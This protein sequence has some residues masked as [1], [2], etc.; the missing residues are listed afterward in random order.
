[1]SHVSE[2][3]ELPKTVAELTKFLSARGIV[4]TKKK[5]DELEKLAALAVE[6]DVEVDPEGLTEDREETIRKKLNLLDGE[7]ILPL[8]ESLT[9]TSDLTAAPRITLRDILNYQLEAKSV[10][11]DGELKHPYKSEAWQMTRDKFVLEMS[12]AE[13]TDTKF[14]AIQSKVKPRTNQCDPVTK[15]P[16][17]SVWIIISNEDLG[18][19]I[20]SAFCACKAGID[21]HCRHVS[22]TLYKLSEYN[23]RD[24]E[25]T[26]VTSLPC[27]WNKPSL[28]KSV[29]PATL[30][31]LQ[32]EVVPWHAKGVTLQEI[33]QY[34]P[35]P[36]ATAL[37]RVEDFLSMTKEF[38]PQAA[39]LDVFFKRP[40]KEPKDAM[41]NLTVITPHDKIKAHFEMHALMH[42]ECAPVCTEELLD[43][44]KYTKE[45]ALTIDHATRG[46]CDNDN[47]LMMRQGLLTSS[48][49]HNILHSTNDSQ[50]ANQL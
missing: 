22:A 42:D 11:S 6:M 15:L 40:Q 20:R 39:L 33:Q 5:K 43:K 50:K 19:E 23:Q 27:Q 14:V 35:L 46:Q 48:E 16:Y 13:Y 49:F 7:Q 26:S 24:G 18:P 30:Q 38:C 3:P 29:R 44:L 45:E 21:G 2:T 10:Y 28:S 31:E 1:M 17:Y 4:C 34:N 25:K 12:Y 36:A 32:V 9:A 41:P 37:P 8:P 47:W